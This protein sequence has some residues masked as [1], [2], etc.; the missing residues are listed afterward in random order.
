MFCA[1][2][3]DTNGD[4]ADSDDDCNGV[5]Y[6]QFNSNSSGMMHAFLSFQRGVLEDG[7]DIMEVITQVL[8]YL[9]E[10]GIKTISEQ[11][12]LN[13]EGIGLAKSMILFVTRDYLSQQNYGLDKELV[14]R[15]IKRK[16]ENK[17]IVVVL[18]ERM[19]KADDWKEMS[20]L[21]VAIDGLPCIDMVNILDSNGEKYYMLTSQIFVNH[22]TCFLSVDSSF[23]IFHISSCTCVSLPLSNS[24]YREMR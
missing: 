7:R 5:P 16:G 20:P 2:F 14:R 15:Y 3:E 1:C 23:R 24:I 12:K 18:E 19:R 8:A 21:G 22:F 13:I 6:K 9:K 11:D 4:S 17:H 10:K